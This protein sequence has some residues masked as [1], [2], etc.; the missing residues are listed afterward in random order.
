M[1]ECSKCGSE[2]HFD[3]AAFCRRCGAELSA[4]VAV[5]VIAEPNHLNVTEKI[6]IKAKQAVAETESA[7]EEFTVEDVSDPEDRA[8]DLKSLGASTHEGGIDKLLK[9]YGSDGPV[10][11]AQPC[12][13]ENT[14]GTNS[15]GIESASDYLLNDQPQEHLDEQTTTAGLVQPTNPQLD[16]LSEI[17][18]KLT[19]IEDN[20]VQE[21]EPEVKNPMGCSRPKVV[22]P[23]LPVEEKH[24]LLDSLNKSLHNEPLPS[25]QPFS[26]GNQEHDQAIDTTPHSGSLSKNI[27]NDNPHSEAVHLDSAVVEPEPIAPAIPIAHIRG[28]KLTLP[29]KTRMLPGDRIYHNDQEYLVRK[30]AIDKRSWIL[31][32]VLVAVLVII[33]IVQSLTAPAPMK[34]TLFG[35]VTNSE[36]NEVLAGISVSIPQLNISTVTDEN[37]LFQFKGVANGRYDVKLEGGLYEARFFPV[38]IQDNQSDIVFGN[39]TPLLPQIS[40][41]STPPRS[42]VVVPSPAEEQPEYGTLKIQCNIADANV[43]LDGKT[44][45]KISQ[46]FKRL[47]PGARNIVIQAD[48]Y[49]EIAQVVNI[50]G[51]QTTELTANLL[52]L[53]DNQPIEYTADDFF[54]QAEALHR[55]QKYIEAVGYYTLA[56]AKNSSM[57]KAYLRRGEAHLQAGKR[58]NARADY[59]SAADLYINSAMYSQAIACYDKIIEFQPD[60]S[61]AFSLRGWAKISAGDYD[62]GLNDLQKALSFTPDDQ[63][64]LFDVGKAFYVTNRYKDAEKILKKIRKHGDEYPEI[65]GY[66]ALTE[67]AQG[68]ENDARKSYDSFR[69]VASSAQIA[70]MSNQSGWQ[71]LTALAGN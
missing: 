13:D 16:R 11:Q 7:G 42:V 27:V 48:G 30:G 38:I 12:G 36:T 69:K 14:V 17:Q 53:N 35:V 21:N 59:R 46:V 47:K 20:D 66:L 44:L 24:R 55:E 31:G 23:A 64:A 61:D 43:L 34:A 32:G 40:R 29:D 15:L 19:P 67:L 41:T 52:A 25:I 68:D 71:R 62:N 10:E 18:S 49:Q 28:N 5:E 50:V 58:L 3:G 45:G 51:G 65:Y 56:L 33:M 22:E 1:I 2:N 37:G 26:A 63:Q 4:K 54:E 9:L 70:R 57:V 39:V 8:A 60:A 6:H